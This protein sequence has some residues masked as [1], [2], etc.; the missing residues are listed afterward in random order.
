MK[1]N[2]R[3]E[4]LRDVGRR[5]SD[6]VISNPSFKVLPPI[7]KE[8]NSEEEEDGNED[9]QKSSNENIDT[10][11]VAEKDDAIEEKDD[12]IINDIKDQ[13]EFNNNMNRGRTRSLP[14]SSG[15]VTEDTEGLVHQI[16]EGFKVHNIK[17]AQVDRM[18]R[19]MIQ[20]DRDDDSILSGEE[21]RTCLSLS[22]V[23]MR[24]VTVSWLLRLAMRGSRRYSIETIAGI[25]Q[26]AVYAA[27]TDVDT[28]ESSDKSDCEWKLL[29]E[30]FTNL[31]VLSENKT[32]EMIAQSRE[33]C[34][35][36]LR[37]AL[38]SHP[39]YRQGNLN[40]G[41]LH[42]LHLTSFVDEILIY[43]F[44]LFETWKS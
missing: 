17:Q 36:Q 9:E 10:E 41:K 22:G 6:S 26:R 39:L 30:M 43:S 11:I 29:L 7:N 23:K 2:D 4:D 5:S 16:V 27:Q 34:L 14:L 19:M 31:S 25:L 38:V 13:E 15:G 12:P 8:D 21:V 24:A 40:L 37:E 20:K 35:V 28:F 3:A 42:D 44:V 33:K 18:V 32:E 1:D